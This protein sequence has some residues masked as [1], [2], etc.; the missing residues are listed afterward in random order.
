MLKKPLWSSK[1]RL[2]QAHYA[3]RSYSWIIPPR[4]GRRLI[5]FWQRPRAGSS[6]QGFLQPVRRRPL[7]R[8]SAT[9]V[10][11]RSTFAASSGEERSKCSASG[12]SAKGAAAPW[13]IRKSRVCIGTGRM[14]PSAMRCL[15]RRSH[16]HCQGGY[17]NIPARGL[18]LLPARGNLIFGNIFRDNGK[19]GNSGNSDLATAG[20]IAGSAVPRNCF[21]ANKAIGSALTSAP[22]GIE[23]PGLDGRP[24]GRPGTGSDAVLLAQLGCATLSGQCKVPDSFYPRQTRI[25]Y[26][27]LPTLPSMPDPCA[28]IPQKTFC[29]T[30]EPVGG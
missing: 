19:F 5:H 13:A 17:P 30:A 27:P 1:T 16:S 28:G 12:A 4:A 3:A 25:D 7:M 18:C 23:Q 21:Y 11:C 8:M 22:V 24:C 10:L 26:V 29:R 15:T 6:R 2:D 9:S 20:L 14:R